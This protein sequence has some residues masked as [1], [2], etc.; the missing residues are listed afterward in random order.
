[1]CGKFQDKIRP[2]TYPATCVLVN[3]CIQQLQLLMW[4]IQVKEF[5]FPSND[6]VINFIKLNNSLHFHQI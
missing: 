6:T 2:L 4:Q 3:Y 1:M 5:F